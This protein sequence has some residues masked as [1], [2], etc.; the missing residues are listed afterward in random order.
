MVIKSDRYRHFLAHIYGNQPD[1]WDNALTDYDRWRVITN[2][3]TRMR[4]CTV[5]GQLELTSK[6]T[7]EEAPQGYLPWFKHPMRKARK[8]NIIFGHWAALQGGIVENNVFALDSGCVW[9][10]KLTVMRLGDNK[11]ISVSCKDCI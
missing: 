3:F 11:M 7:S 8:D 4:F 2:Y 6:G 9:G 1:K 10:G 5:D